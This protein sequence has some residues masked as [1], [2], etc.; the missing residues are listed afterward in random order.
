MTMPR[1][2]TELVWPTFSTR[3]RPAAQDVDDIPFADWIPE[4]PSIL[5]EQAPDQPPPPPP[6]CQVIDDC[7]RYEMERELVALEHIRDNAYELAYAAAW[8]DWEAKGGDWG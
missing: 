6:G 3:P 4:V 2:F 1:F 8:H 7:P 5:D